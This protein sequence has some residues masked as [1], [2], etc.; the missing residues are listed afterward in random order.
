MGGMLG[1]D[2]HRG[3]GGG[4]GGACC[5]TRAQAR[6]DKKRV[7]QIE[8]RETKELFNEARKEREE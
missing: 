4:C 1:D 3:W 2:P 5:N 7:K 8:K 6:K